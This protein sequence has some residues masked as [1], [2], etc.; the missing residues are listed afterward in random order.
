VYVTEQVFG[1][2]ITPNFRGS[3]YTQPGD[4]L[5]QMGPVVSGAPPATLRPGE[6]LYSPARSFRLTMQPADGN[7]V[8]SYVETSNLPR[9]WPGSQL[10]PDQVTWLP[11][12]AAGTQNKSA[13]RLDMQDD[14]NLVVYDGAGQAVWNSGTEGNPQ[15]F[16]R[17]QDDG[18]LLIFAQGDQGV[19]W[20]S[21][22]SAAE[23]PG[24]N[25][26]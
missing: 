9:I 8:L 23:A 6:S 3:D 17:L 2:N 12:W 15:A 21:N 5:C 1:L 20:S 18:N 19:I 11:V 24:A 7:L 26:A 4:I 13:S 10:T 22:T 16:F 14:G 25:A